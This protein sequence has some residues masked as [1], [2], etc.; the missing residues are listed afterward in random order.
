METM[1]SL[2]K[3]MV[4]NLLPQKFPFVMVDAMHSYTETSLVS[5][6]KIQQDNIFV[7]NNIFLEAGLIEHMAQSVALHTGYQYF[8]RNE[9]APTGYIGS[10]K[11]IEIKK[12]P[13]LNNIIQSEVTILQEF[14]GITLVNIV[15]TLNNEEIANGQMKTVLAK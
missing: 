12:L 10:I 9:T 5:G 4:E 7:K 1:A 3:E 11:E 8:L 2:E 13:Q 14:A 6:L 15:T